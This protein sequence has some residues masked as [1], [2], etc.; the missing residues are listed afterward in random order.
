MALARRLQEEELRRTR[1][2]LALQLVGSPVQSAGAVAEVKQ[3][4]EK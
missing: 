1:D 3:K 4:F 2:R